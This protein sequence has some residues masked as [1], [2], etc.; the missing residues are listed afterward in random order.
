MLAALSPRRFLKAGQLSAKCHVARYGPTTHISS[1]VRGRR[2]VKTVSFGG[3][4]DNS[5]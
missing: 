1:R 3:A 4:C 2:L 5:E